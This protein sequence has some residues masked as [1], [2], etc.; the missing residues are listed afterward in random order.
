MRTSGFPIFFSDQVKDRWY[1]SRYNMC[2]FAS[3]RSLLPQSLEF[4]FLYWS[5][6][7]C[8][9]IQN[10]LQGRNQTE[11][12]GVTRSTAGVLFLS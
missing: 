1:Q 11:K 7:N 4:V 3:G 12:T 9:D 6:L 10:F 8:S 2:V 5:Y